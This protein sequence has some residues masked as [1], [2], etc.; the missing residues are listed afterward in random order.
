MSATKLRAGDLGHLVEVAAAGKDM[1]VLANFTARH[2]SVHERL[3][4]GKAMRE[5]VPRAE[6]ARFDKNPARPD[7]VAIL[8]KQNATRVQKLVPVR[9]A[10]MLASPFAFLR[11]SAAVSRRSC[12]HAVTGLQ[13]NAARRMSPTSAST[14]GRTKPRVR[15]QRFRRGPRRPN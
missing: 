8:E 14:P 6:H 5:K 12:N 9:F 15:H 13:V 11:G 1:A 7:P 2:P 3:A 10:R 4:A